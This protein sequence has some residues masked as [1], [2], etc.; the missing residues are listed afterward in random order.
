MQKVIK[1]IMLF[2]LITSM[3]IS[4]SG[5]PCVPH[6]SK[7]LAPYDHAPAGDSR[8]AFIL[9]PEL[10]SS[11]KFSKCHSDSLLTRIC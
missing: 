4:K 5:L 9:V 8:V 7:E 11:S 2:G 1:L 10:Q 3:I 6:S